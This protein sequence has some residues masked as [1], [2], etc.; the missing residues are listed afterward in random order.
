MKINVITSCDYRIKRKIEYGF[1][2]LFQPWRIDFQFEP[3]VSADCVNI[4]YGRQFPSD[5]RKALWIRASEEFLSCISESKLPDIS[6]VAWFEFSGKRLPKLYPSP[7]VG[8]ST[9]VDFDIAAAA[10]ILA[11]NF[12]D[13]ISLERDEFDRMRAMD[14]LQDKLGILEYPVVNYY[15]KF[16][17]EVIHQSTGALIEEKKYG[18]SSFALALSHDIDYT[19]SLN[20][21]MIRRNVVG[22]AILNRE[23]LYPQERIRKLTFPALAL[24]G[25][26]P[27]R[28][29]MTFLRNIERENN[30]RSTFFIKTG[31]TSKEDVNYSCTSGM[32]REFLKSLSD[33]GFEIGIHPSMKTYIDL[34]HLL[35]EKNRLEN[36]LGR[37]VS[38]V[39]QH[40]LKFT[41]SKTVDIWEKA[42]LKYDSTLG[43]SRRVGFR[44][45]VAF[46]FPLYNFASDR[47]ST[48]TELP[49]VFMDG[50]VVESGRFETERALDKMSSLIHEVRASQGAA[51]ILFHNSISDPVDFPGYEHIYREIIAQARKDNFFLGSVKSIAEHFA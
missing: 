31:A 43:F 18:D 20:P 1:T 37:S 30:L 27:P 13:L 15:S 9:Y 11:S 40:Y 5:P 44:N 2:V 17:K 50:T 22:H 35:A 19:S 3:V 28:K 12:Q 7:A 46:P 47:I 51:S 49:L 45:S 16:L 26:D 38:S 25:Y 8:G 6:E 48:V 23:S 10:F 34:E 21:R 14:S 33:S 32:M 29:G 39:R 41:A 4:F 42:D 36:S 24:L